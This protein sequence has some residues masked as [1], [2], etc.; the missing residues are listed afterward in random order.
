[1]KPKHTK[2]KHTEVSRQ[3]RRDQAKV[4]KAVKVIVRE[5][6]MNM[7]I[8]GHRRRPNGDMYIGEKS[9]VKK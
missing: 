1:M 3:Y 6:V 8:E 5:I 2:I 9:K 4:T 7:L